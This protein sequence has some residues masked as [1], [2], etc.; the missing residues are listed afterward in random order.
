MDGQSSHEGVGQKILL[1]HV[2]KCPL[3]VQS[4]LFLNLYQYHMMA[5][6]VNSIEHLGVQVKHIPAGCMGLVQ[7][8]EV[9][10]DKPLKGRIQSK[11]KDWLIVALRTE[12][13]PIGQIK[14]PSQGIVAG[15]IT[16]ALRG[17]D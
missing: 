16:N 11:Y 10:I 12:L 4:V 5:P 7:P 14:A 8:I 17:L 9:G 1:P 3:G 15:W 6:L 13:N 2:K